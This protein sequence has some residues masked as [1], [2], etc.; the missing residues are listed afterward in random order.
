MRTVTAFAE[1]DDALV[2]KAVESGCK[3]LVVYV[4]QRLAGFAIASG[5]GLARMLR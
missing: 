2:R 3:T 4:G 1:H 5:S